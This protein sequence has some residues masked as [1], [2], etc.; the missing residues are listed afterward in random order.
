MKKLIGL[1]LTLTVVFSFSACSSV[2][3]SEAVERI[4]LFGI[5]NGIAYYDAYFIDDVDWE[6]SDSDHVPIAIET[7]RRCKDMAEAEGV[8]RCMVTGMDANGNTA[9][10]WGGIDGE[11]VI[12]IYEE[13]M[14]DYEYF[15]TEGDLEELN[16]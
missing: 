10:S 14:F 11:M 7:I 4:E 6:N 12:R 8:E 13:N 2:E 9:F 16:A 3:P 15:V 1:I 5:E